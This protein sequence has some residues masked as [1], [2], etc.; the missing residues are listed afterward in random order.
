MALWTPP[1]RCSAGII[2]SAVARVLLPRH[3]GRQPSRRRWPPRPSDRSGRPPDP[4]VRRG[5]WLLVTPARRSLWAHRC[6]TTTSNMRRY[7]STGCRRPSP[8][9][10]GRR[11]RQRGSTSGPREDL[12][13]DLLEPRMCRRSLVRGDRL[14]FVAHGSWRPPWELSRASCPVGVL[15]SWFA[16]FRGSRTRVTLNPYLERFKSYFGLI[17]REDVA[18]DTLAHDLEAASGSPSS[19]GLALDAPATRHSRGDGW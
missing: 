8:S 19:G 15:P 14:L 18:R 4:G 10:T 16:C 13:V 2:R 11:L 1:R 7:A 12:G 17:L 6:F 5:L 9:I 3:E